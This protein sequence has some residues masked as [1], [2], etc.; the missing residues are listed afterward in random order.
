MEFFTINEFIEKYQECDCIE[1]NKLRLTILEASEMIFAQVSPCFRD[2]NWNYKNVPKAIKNASMEQARF[3]LMYEIPHIDTKK[4]RAGEMEAELI[5]EYSTL[6]LT[7]LSNAGYLYRGNPI[8][9][10]MSLDMEFGGE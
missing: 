7:M 6:A 1:E 9:F 2:T 3:L 4:L 5:T 10:N 8:N